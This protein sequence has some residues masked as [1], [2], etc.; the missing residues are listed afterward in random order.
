MHT[1][2][3]LP[4]KE[5]RFYAFVMVEKTNLTICHGV[6]GTIQAHNDRQ[7]NEVDA[8]DSSRHMEDPCALLG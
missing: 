3:R 2:W 6:M 1:T 5:R 7:G 8:R 4:E